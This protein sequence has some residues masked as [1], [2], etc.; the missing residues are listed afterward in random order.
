MV[1]Y[2]SNSSEMDGAKGRDYEEE[3]AWMS[4]DSGKWTVGGVLEEAVIEECACGGFESYVRD[5]RG[6]IGRF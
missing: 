2:G 1:V 3:C 5:F 4:L 6:E